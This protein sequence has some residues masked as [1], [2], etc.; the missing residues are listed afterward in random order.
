MSIKKT[1]HHV[2]VKTRHNIAQRF[3]LAVDHNNL[4]DPRNK[5]RSAKIRNGIELVKMSVLVKVFFA[6][7]ANQ[8]E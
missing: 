1:L 2:N 8:L 6:S 3:F 5:P 7:H 4:D